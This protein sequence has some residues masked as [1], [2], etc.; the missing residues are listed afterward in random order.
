RK[1]QQIE[2][3][4]GSKMKSLIIQ[5]RPAIL[6]EYDEVGRLEKITNPDGKII[7]IKKYSSL[8]DNIANMSVYR[9]DEHPAL[10]SAYA[11]DAFGR[12]VAEWLALSDNYD[13]EENANGFEINKSKTP[14]F[15]YNYQ[16]QTAKTLGNIETIVNLDQISYAQSNYMD[17]L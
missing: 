2:Y 10:E 11:Y 6:Y 8:D 9:G 17:G 15:S 3:A 5:D 1:I 7:W 12:L 14:L 13:R 4:F 16:L